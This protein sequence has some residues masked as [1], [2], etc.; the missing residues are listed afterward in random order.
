MSVVV[1]CLYVL[2]GFYSLFIRPSLVLL[3]WSVQFEFRNFN[4]SVTFY[5]LF[6]WKII[7]FSIVKK[8]VALWGVLSIKG[9]FCDILIWSFLG[10]EVVSIEI[11]VKWTVVLAHFSCFHRS[12]RIKANKFFKKHSF[13]KSNI[14][15][16]AFFV[17]FAPQSFETMPLPAWY[18]WVLPI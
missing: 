18:V 17:V 4:Q 7:E 10:D 13:W 8:R 3:F 16:H 6:S 12:L 15:K 14:D 2:S 1:L 5:R 9:N 11:S